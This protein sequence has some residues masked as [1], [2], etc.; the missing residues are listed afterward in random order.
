MF[1]SSVYASRVCGD[2]SSMLVQFVVYADSTQFKGDLVLTKN[3]VTTTFG[4]EDSDSFTINSTGE[5]LLMETNKYNLG[6]SS[7][8]WERSTPTASGTAV[9]STLT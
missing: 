8:V 9:E 6:S 7:F 3:G 1:Q 5:I 4:S 2:N